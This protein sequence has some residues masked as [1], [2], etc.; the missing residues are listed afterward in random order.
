MA[1]EYSV[2]TLASSP[3]TLY[4]APPNLTFSLKTNQFVSSNFEFVVGLQKKLLRTKGLKSV[5]KITGHHN[6]GGYLFKIKFPPFFNFKPGQDVE[7]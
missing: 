1:L 4:L 3:C 5:C 6:K 7:K 2:E